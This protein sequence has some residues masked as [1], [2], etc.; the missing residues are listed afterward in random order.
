MPATARSVTVMA[1]RRVTFSTTNEVHI[2]PPT[3]APSTSSSSSSSGP[4]AVGQ[5]DLSTYSEADLRILKSDRRESRLA[6]ESELLLS[7]K[8]DGESERPGAGGG[9]SGEDVDPNT[10]RGEIEGSA[11]PDS[12]DFGYTVEAFNLSE[13]R[14]SGLL[15]AARNGQIAGRGGDDD[16]HRDDAWLQDNAVMDS[17][18]LKRMNEARKRQAEKAAAARRGGAR[19]DVSMEDAVRYVVRLLRPGESV[20]S[21]LR[22]L[23][24]SSL[25]QSG[26]GSMRGVNKAK[27]SWRDRMKQTRLAR[28]RPQRRRHYPKIPELQILTLRHHL[29]N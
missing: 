24:P 13:E 29:V 12:A 2:L 11:L 16:S 22:R 10:V 1:G 5:E 6:A 19:D 27:I 14:D 7:N 20:L 17:E 18:S 8:F 3:D 28:S 25:G 15:R 26:K 4:P 9:D 21:A 23:K